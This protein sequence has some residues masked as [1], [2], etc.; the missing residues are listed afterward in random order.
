MSKGGGWYVTHLPDNGTRRKLCLGD[1]SDTGFAV[2][3][4]QLAE[5]ET[6]VEKKR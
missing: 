6:N 5:Q 1:N 2:M 4:V 3:N